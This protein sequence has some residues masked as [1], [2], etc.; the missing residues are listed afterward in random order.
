M[1]GDGKSIRIFDDPWVRGNENYMADRVNNDCM[2]GSWVCDLFLPGEKE[3]DISKVNNLFKNCDAEFNLALPV[4]KNQVSDRIVWSFT[5]DGMYS[6]K[7]GNRFWHD[8]H[9]TC[10]RESSSSGWG[11]I[12]ILEVPHKVRV[13]L[14]R[15]CRNNIP[16]RNILRIKGIQTS[17]ICPVCTNDVEHVLH[18]FLDCYFAKECWRI[19]GL[20]FDTSQVET[21]SEWLLQRLVEKDN[22]HLVSIAMKL[23]GIWSARNMK[24]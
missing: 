10:K 19:L 3:W 5:K 6:V 24:V 15:I 20:D 22:E 12:W 13:F 7:S 8:N 2:N 11:K 14:W 23:W 21:C 1:V 18:V 17:I 9:S 16:V 4:P